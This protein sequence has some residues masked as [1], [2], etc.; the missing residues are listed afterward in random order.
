MLCAKSENKVEFDPEKMDK[1]GLVKV[2]KKAG[3]EAVEMNPPQGPF[4]ASL[5]RFHLV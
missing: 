4:P 2:I 5:L 3:Y 1:K